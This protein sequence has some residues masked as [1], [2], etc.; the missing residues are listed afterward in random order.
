MEKFQ[1]NPTK[2]THRALHR[3]R[4]DHLLFGVCG[5]LAEYFAL[6]PVLVRLL[7]VLAALVGGNGLLAYVVLAIALPEAGA[8]TI[9]GRAA[10][11]TNLVQLQASAS[12]LGPG[13]SASSG[14]SHRWTRGQELAG[15]ALPALGLL[16]LTG[17]LGWL[18]SFDWALLWPVGLIP[19]GV[20]ILTRRR[21]PS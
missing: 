21:P 8:V 6:D 4:R 15:F 1:A 5:G 9:R 16:F 14:D 2:A 20:A 7:F 18:G 13:L 19:I 10:L 17:D 12:E 11:R 3:S